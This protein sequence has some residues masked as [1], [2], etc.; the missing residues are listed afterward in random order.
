MQNSILKFIH[1][2]S[3]VLILFSFSA[4]AQSLHYHVSKADSLF[5]QKRYTQSL[6]LYQSIFAQ[7]QYTPAMLLKMAYIEEGLDHIAPAVYYLNLFYVATKDERTLIKIKELAGKHGLEGYDFTDRE[8]A[9]NAYYEYHQPITLALTALVVFLLSLMIYQK[10][11]KA[12]PVELWVGFLIILVCLFI[13]TNLPVINATAIIAKPNT[14]VMSGPSAGAS[15]IRIIKEGNRVRVTGEVD[16][17][18]RVKL[19]DK[20]AYIKRDHLLPVS[21]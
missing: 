19:N 6:E 5:Q 7:Q 13:H 11:K 17:W 20:D 16:V 1:I 18:V 2:H 9:F 14:Y 8:Q 10:S 3:I 15:V 12:K 21:L 4:S